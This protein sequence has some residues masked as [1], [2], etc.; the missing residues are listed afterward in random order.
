MKITELASRLKNA[1]IAGKSGVSGLET[2]LLEVE[3]AKS[4]ASKQSV[5][6]ELDRVAVSIGNAIE[7]AESAMESI[8]ALYG[9]KV[10]K[11]IAKRNDS[12]GAVE[13]AETSDEYESESEY[14]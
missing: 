7:A 10:S 8:S 6:N 4:L 1:S 9:K 13:E 12:S 2:A 5:I 3:L 14:R 11:I